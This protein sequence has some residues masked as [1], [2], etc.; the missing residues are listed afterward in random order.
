MF[1]ETFKTKEEALDFAVHNELAKRLRD[2][3]KIEVSDC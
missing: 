2:E 1:A 3:E